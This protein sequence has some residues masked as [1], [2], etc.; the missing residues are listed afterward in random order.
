MTI[1]EAYKNIKSENPNKVVAECLEFADFYAFAVID[2]GTE[3]EAAGGGYDTIHKTTGEKGTFSPVQD[4]DAFF[5]AKK[6]D[7]STLNV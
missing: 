6:I 3:N 4:L 7:I 5:A 2:E 1:Q